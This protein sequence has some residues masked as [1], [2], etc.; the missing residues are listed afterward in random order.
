MCLSCAIPGT[1]CICINFV[2]RGLN[3]VLFFSLFSDYIFDYLVI[4][5]T[6]GGFAAVSTLNQAL[7]YTFKV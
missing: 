6:I 7:K 5:V 2:F 1:V 4:I 3:N